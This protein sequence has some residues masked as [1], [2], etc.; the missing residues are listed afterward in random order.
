[1]SL[2]ASS[3]GLVN[4]SSDRTRGRVFSLPAAVALPDGGRS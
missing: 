3:S 2:R 1:M 4:S